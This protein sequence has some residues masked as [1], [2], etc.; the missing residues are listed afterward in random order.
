[1]KTSTSTNVHH[2]MK[3]TQEITDHTTEGGRDFTT[4][5]FT[6]TDEDGGTHTF[7]LFLKSEAKAVVEQLP[8]DSY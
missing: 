1:M 7:T 2:I 6:A 3:V 8:R 5:K 4:V